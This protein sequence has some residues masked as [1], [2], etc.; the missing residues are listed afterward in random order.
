[1]KA[2]K[3]KTQNNEWKYSF[4]LQNLFSKLSYHKCSR[5]D[6]LLKNGRKKCFARQKTKLLY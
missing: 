2:T 5:L 3:K 4:L 1:M 6:V